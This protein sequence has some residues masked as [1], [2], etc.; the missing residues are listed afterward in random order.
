MGTQQDLVGQ[1]ALHNKL[2][3][4]LGNNIYSPNIE[5]GFCYLPVYLPVC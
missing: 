1:R 3:V 4:Q 2:T 5:S